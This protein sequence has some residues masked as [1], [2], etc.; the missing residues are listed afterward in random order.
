M[1]LT[2]VI[3]VV[4]LALSAVAGGWKWHVD[5][6]APRAGIGAPAALSV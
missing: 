4:V 2:L 5:K 3:L 6:A 1:R